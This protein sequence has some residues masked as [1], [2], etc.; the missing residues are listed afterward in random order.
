MSNIA[1]SISQDDPPEHE[2]ARAWRDR[3]G[4]SVMQLEELTGYSREA[5]YAFEK[6]KRWDGKHSGFSWHRYKLTCAAVELQIA[7]GKVFDW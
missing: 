5:V 3:M 2:R 1:E 7:T 4:L 6:G